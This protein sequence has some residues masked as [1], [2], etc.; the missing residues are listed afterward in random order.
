MHGPFFADQSRRDASALFGLSAKDPMQKRPTPCFQNARQAALALALTGALLATAG[1]DANNTDDDADRERLSGSWFI[2]DLRVDGDPAFASLDSQ[3][4][5]AILFRLRVDKNENELFLAQSLNDRGD[6]LLI[7]RG[8]F[9]VDADDGELRL[10]TTARF[11][12]LSY[13][14]E[15]SETDDPARVDLMAEDD[16]DA[17]DLIDLLALGGFGNVEDV[18]I[19]IARERVPTSSFRPSLLGRPTA[20]A[21]TP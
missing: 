21:A 11:L 18:A 4:P 12:S 7:R 15:A 20:P 17:E 2:T 5:N 16:T 9:E 3:Y 10:N 8:T 14:F 19:T 6:T 13:D 1:C